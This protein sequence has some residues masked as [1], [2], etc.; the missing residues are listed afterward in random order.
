MLWLS[1]G[2]GLVIS[3]LFVEFLG[4]AA[5]GLVVPRYN[6]LF[7]DRPLCCFFIVHLCLYSLDSIS[8][9]VFQS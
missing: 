1:E 3:L 4:L 5:G 7:W 9:N 6:A 8:E 2:I